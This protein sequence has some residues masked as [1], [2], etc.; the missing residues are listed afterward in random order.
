MTEETLGQKM[1]REMK[2]AGIPCKIIKIKFD[3]KIEKEVRDYLMKIEEAHKKAA[4]SK[5]IFDARVI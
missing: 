1:A 4:K 5:L 3:P 2:K